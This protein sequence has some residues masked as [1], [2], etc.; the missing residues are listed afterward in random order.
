MV[1]AIV[2]F[3]VER[4]GDFLIQE[5][6]FL[7]SVN[8]KVMWLKDELEWMQSYIA[9]AEAKQIDNPMIRK[10]LSDITEISYEIE[11]VLDKLFLQLKP[12]RLSSMPSF[13]KSK[14]LHG[15]GKKIEEF[16]IRI[17]DLS[18]RRELYGL[19]DLDHGKTEGQSSN[20]TLGRLKQLRRVTSFTVDKKIIGF[21]DEVNVLLAKLLDKEPCRSV[22]SI[23]GMGGLG[24]TTLAKKLYHTN[25]VKMKF[26][27]RAWVS[28][29]QDYNTHDLLIRIIRSFG[30]TDFTTEQLKNFYEEELERY[31][32]GSLI[33]RSFLVVIDDVWQKE[34]WESLKRAFPDSEKGSR[35]IIT[36]RIWKVAESSDE[37][38]HA[39]KLRFL[40]LDESW[41]LLCE[42][43]FGNSDAN[44]DFEI[45]VKKLIRL[46]I[47]EGFVPRERYQTLEDMA[48]CNFDELVGRSLIL[49]E[50]RS[51]GRVATCRVHD[52]LRDLAIRK[53][54]ELK[55]LH[56]CDQ[57]KPSTWDPSSTSTCRQQA[58]YSA[59][60]VCPALQISNPNMRSILF[61]T[62]EKALRVTILNFPLVY[63]FR[64]LRMLDFD[65]Y[66]QRCSGNLYEGIGNLIY[67]K[68]LG[69][70]KLGFNK[71]PSSILKLK[72][73][74][75]LDLYSDGVEI[76]LP[77][78]VYKLQELR[79]LF[80]SLTGHL[81]IDSLTKLQSLKFVNSESW[82]KINSGKLVNLRELS[83]YSKFSNSG[84]KVFRFDTVVKLPRLEQ[85]S[86]TLCAGDCFASLQPLS[87]CSNLIDLRLYGNSGK[88]PE[89]I[90]VV[91]PNLECL[92]LKNTCFKDDPMHLLGK[93]PSLV[94]LYLD[95]NFFYGKEIVC[96]AWSFPRLELLKIGM[97]DLLEEWQVEEGAMPKLRGLSMPRN[98]C[99]RI[100]VRLRSIPRPAES[101]FET[102]E[103][104]WL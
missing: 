67:L 6:E 7:G 62:P 72:R 89:D 51:W 16:Q 27:R 29:S 31:L 21:E 88:L 75:T 98:T 13:I 54:R 102:G 53:A 23:Y 55:L 15:T 92:L 96:T 1:D 69:L 52:L 35:V 42:K 30:F 25:D 2:S 94:I 65:G 8:K 19:Q 50:K 76:E 86:I 58:I 36:T 41:Q 103:F 74:Q 73:L 71:L 10:W 100:P 18:R 84:G 87:S 78:K 17:N 39:H 63:K 99:L 101:E 14:K 40:R 45:D 56:I 3:V 77:N 4:L 70:R 60:D 9:N 85:L 20:T 44:D 34:A 5:A 47:A 43:T 37:R 57:L 104:Y 46:W 81:R 28:V 38:T 33:G 68:H 12:G 61:F 64:F 97:D 24:K 80:G 22:I 95:F 32:F 11:D 93:L 26:N 59:V 82:S 48:K 79:Y 91:L 90:D 83:I 49:I 66:D